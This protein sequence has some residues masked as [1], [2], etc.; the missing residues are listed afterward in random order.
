MIRPLAEIV[1]IV[2]LKAHK[3]P[4]EDRLYRCVGAKQNWIPAPAFAGGDPAQE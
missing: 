1:F 2:I 4:L 3:V